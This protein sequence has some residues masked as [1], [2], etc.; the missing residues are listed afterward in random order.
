MTGQ[1]VQHAE[2]TME[3]GTS[4]CQCQPGYF[5]LDGSC[6][7]L[8]PVGGACSGPGQCV[9]NSVCTP[10]SDGT[11]VCDPAHFFVWKGR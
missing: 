6:H 4:V 3:N 11:C 8:S 1:C 7:E 10:P 9:I 5:Q 2:C